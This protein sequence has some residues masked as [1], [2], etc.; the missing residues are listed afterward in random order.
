MKRTLAVLVALCAPLAF[1]QQAAPARVAGAPAVERVQAP[2]YSDLYCAG[3]ITNES[4]GKANFL[5]AGTESPNQ[6]Q[7]H[8]GDTVFVEGSGLQEGNRLSV[9]R[10][11]HD[12]NR[13][14]AF[15][16]QPAAIAALGQPYAELGRLRIMS[17]RGKTAIAQVEFSCAPMVAGD[18]VEPYQE[19]PPVAFR[20]KTSFER[21]PADQGSVTGRIV[22]AR[23][24][25]YLLGV[26][27][28]VYINAGSNKGVKVGDYFRAVRGY[29]PTK[30][31]PIDGLA[32]KVSQSEETQKYNSATS[33]ATYA[34]LPKRALGE[35][36]VINVTPTSSTAMIT[37][38]VEAVTV[39]DTVELEGGGQQ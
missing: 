39:G 18:I 33:P 25:D 6:T 27:Q 26:G 2:T 28:K 32:Y 36:I 31:Q 9:I 34:Q 29:D 38:A 10:N 14:R 11:L 30:V 20:G 5:V 13:S 16:E 24:F 35:M 4:H 23:E 37:Y 1:A 7:F 8:Q 22:M 19:K 17:V 15:P 21:F 3:F 12:P